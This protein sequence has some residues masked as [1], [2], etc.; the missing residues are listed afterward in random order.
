VRRGQSLVEFAVV[1]LVVYMLLAAILTF[2]HA[3]YVAQGLQTAADLGAREISRTPLPAA[4]NFDDA[5]NS[6]NE[7][8]GGAI[9]HSKVRSRIFDDA[10]L[11]IDLEEF[12]AKFPTDDPDG[13]N[14]FRDLV[15]TLP[16]LNQQLVTMMI[17]DNGLLRYPGALLARP[18]VEPPDGVSFDEKSPYASPTEY[19]SWIAG[20]EF[21]V[22]VP[23]ITG[24]AADGSET[25]RWVSIVEEIDTEELPTDNDGPNADPFSINSPQQ[26]IVALRIN[27]PFQSAS[28]SSFRPNPE[29]PFE[30]TIGSPNLANEDGSVTH[31]TYAGANGLGVQQ[32]LGQRVRPY[33][34]VISAQAIYRREIFE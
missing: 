32:A 34:R 20:D 14:I 1:A 11:V 18:G 16:L 25:L 28:M 17:V 5:P 23:V 12:Y 30:P 7:D 27:F 29:G 33:R 10:L 6:E 9:H 22:E 26:G 3:L 31:G 24:R 19:K 21:I 2:G 4:M 15:P 13:P 8:E